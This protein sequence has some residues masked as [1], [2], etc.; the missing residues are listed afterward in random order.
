MDHLNS[1]ESTIT[2][3]GPP[4]Q[5]GLSRGLHGAFLKLKQLEK[6]LNMERVTWC[7]L[8]YLIAVICT[9]VLPNFHQVI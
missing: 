2:D 9:I 1:V 4:K 8:L 5:S 7:T 6:L 3:H